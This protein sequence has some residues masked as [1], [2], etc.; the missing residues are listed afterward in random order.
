[1]V[2]QQQIS[3]LKKFEKEIEKDGFIDANKIYMMV[4][5]VIEDRIYAPKAK[6]RKT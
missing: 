6:V 1:M 5:E 2:D 4:Q 3:E